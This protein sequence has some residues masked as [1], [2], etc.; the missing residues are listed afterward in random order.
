VDLSFHLRRRRM[1]YHGA[2][3]LSMHKINTSGAPSEG[4]EGTEFE[5]A[6]VLASL[7]PLGVVTM[8][9][10]PLSLIAFG[11]L[12]RRTMEDSLAPHDQRLKLGPPFSERAAARC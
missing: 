12:R 1:L 10:L 7:G 2:A 3:R 4:Y 5:T 8:G 9:T 6:A 11:W